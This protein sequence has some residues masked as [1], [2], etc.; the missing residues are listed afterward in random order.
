MEELL[1]PKKIKVEARSTA[2]NAMMDGNVSEAHPRNLVKNVA[3]DFAGSAVLALDKH[4][5]LS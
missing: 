2:T 1:N 5:S 3:V 4:S